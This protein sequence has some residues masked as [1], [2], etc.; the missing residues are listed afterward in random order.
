MN[1]LRRVSLVR[2]LLLCGSIVAIGISATAIALAVGSPAKPPAKPLANAIHDALAGAHQNSVAGFS[3]DVKLTD[4]L[5]EGANLAAGDTGGGGSG[6]GQLASSPLIGGGS[7]RLW[8]AADGRVRLELQTE[9]G[10]TQIVY[11]GKQAFMY[12]AANNTVYRFVPQTSAD[13]KSR[14]MQK[15][16]TSGEP[17]SGSEV[18]S[19][20]KIEEQLAK[21]QKHVTVSGAT[22][23]NVGGQPAYTVRVS[24]REGGSLIGGAELSFDARHGLP[25]RAALYS[26]ATS[27]PVIELATEH[28][29][30][31]PVESSV[32]DIKPPS[33]A[34]VV[35]VKPPTTGGA[36]GTSNKGADRNGARPDVS[37]S[38]KGPSSIAVVKQS[39]KDAA[40]DP[41]AGLPQV[42]I[43][44][45]KATE[46]QTQLGT[47]LSFERSGVRYLVGGF[48][49]PGAIEAFARGL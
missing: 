11:D 47:V 22:P 5:L 4:H 49:T 39:G 34:K 38:G 40:K 41:L 48:L 35:E 45:G 33:G 16:S 9:K 13:A 12:D 42:S 44:S 8:V 36:G 7:G 46:L 32:F 19:V 37:V 14:Q 28:V 24:P 18:P 30:Y 31:G 2:L 23:D 10:D 15:D 26:S 25:L 17:S 29:S 43:G 1:I 20:A 21:A 3:A 27:S 6:A